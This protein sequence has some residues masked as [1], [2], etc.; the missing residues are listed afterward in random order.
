[1][2]YQT[3]PKCKGNNS[4]MFEKCTCLQ[5][6]IPKKDCVVCKGT[7]KAP[8]RSCDGSGKVYIGQ[9]P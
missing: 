8:C 4:K 5:S 2:A 9:N 3:C 1:M 7:G 6:G